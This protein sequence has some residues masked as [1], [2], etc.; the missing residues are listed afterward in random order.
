MEDGSSIINPRKW[1]EQ[2]TYKVA[3][4]LHICSEALQRRAAPNRALRTAGVEISTQV[5]ATEPACIDGKSLKHLRPVQDQYPFA[6][7]AVA[8]YGIDCEAKDRQG[9]LVDAKD[10]SRF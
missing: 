5:P 8:R 2:C 10:R 9:P 3:S 6:D 1:W 4:R 7:D